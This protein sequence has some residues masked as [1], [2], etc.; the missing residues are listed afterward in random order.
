MPAPS[1]EPHGPR[2]PRSKGLA[3]GLA[4][5]DPEAAGAAARALDE[6]ER[7]ARAEGLTGLLT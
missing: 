1:A 3:S 7:L 4:G 2:A 6:L 5:R